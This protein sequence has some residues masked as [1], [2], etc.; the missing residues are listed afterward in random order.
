MRQFIS[1]LKFV[2]HAMAKNEVRYYLNGEL[3]ESVNQDSIRL[4][5]TDG[6]RLAKIDLN[7]KD[8]SIP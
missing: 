3:L 2:S 7:V 8:H 5:A 6:Y 1:A 4:V